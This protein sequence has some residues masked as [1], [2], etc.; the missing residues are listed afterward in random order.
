MIAESPE[1]RYICAGDDWECYRPAQLALVHTIARHMEKSHG[2]YIIVTGDYHIADI[3][4]P[5][6]PCW[7]VI[8][9]VGGGCVS[10]RVG[11]LGEDSRAV[12]SI[13]KNTPSWPAQPHI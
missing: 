8:F 4:V 10:S 3:K 12:S 9:P 2:C 1:P 11:V 5:H 7:G 13:R 6:L